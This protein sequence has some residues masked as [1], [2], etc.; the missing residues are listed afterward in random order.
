QMNFPRI[1]LRRS[2]RSAGCIFVPAD[3]VDFRRKNGGNKIYKQLSTSIRVTLRVYKFSP[4]DG[5]DF[6][7][8]SRGTK[9]QMNFPRICLRRSA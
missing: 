7:R 2:A 5:A 4:A 9:K 6:R 3:G 8:K 1:C